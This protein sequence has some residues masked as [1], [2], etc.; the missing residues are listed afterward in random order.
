MIRNPYLMTHVLV[1]KNNSL[2]SFES[3]VLKCNVR[4]VVLITVSLSLYI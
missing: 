2:L 4:V 1:A 3:I